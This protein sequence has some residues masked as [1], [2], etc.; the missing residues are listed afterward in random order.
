MVEIDLIGGG[1]IAGC[2][3]GLLAIGIGWWMAGVTVLEQVDK[4][5]I[6]PALVPVLKICFGIPA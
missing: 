1:E 2:Q 4:D 6:E 3:K 5:G